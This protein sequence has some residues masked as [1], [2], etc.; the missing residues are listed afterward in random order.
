MEPC[1]PLCTR[2]GSTRGLSQVNVATREKLTTYATPGAQW[3][4]KA[5]GRKVFSKSLHLGSPFLLFLLLFQGFAEGQDLATSAARRAAQSCELRAPHQPV[6]GHRSPWRCYLPSEHRLH[7]LRLGLPAASMERA[8]KQNSIRS[9]KGLQTL[10]KLRCKVSL[11]RGCLI[12]S[13]SG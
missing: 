12:F 2:A 3:S 10:E 13:L 5:L 7:L 6:D 11:K 4:A 1:A 8:T 9:I